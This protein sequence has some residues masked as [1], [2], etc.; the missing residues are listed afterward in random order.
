VYSAAQALVPVAGEERVHVGNIDS[1]LLRVNLSDRFPSTS[2][3]LNV[4]VCG[5]QK[6]IVV[7]LESLRSLGYSDEQVFLYDSH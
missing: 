2:K 6:M 4:V 1:D 5:P 3:S 7:L